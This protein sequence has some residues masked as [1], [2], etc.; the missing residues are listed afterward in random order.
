MDPFDMLNVTLSLHSRFVF[1]PFPCKNK[2]VEEL[3]KRNTPQLA[4]HAG[5]EPQPEKNQSYMQVVARKEQNM[6]ANIG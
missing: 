5:E 4:T 2:K 6:P 3:T 1:C